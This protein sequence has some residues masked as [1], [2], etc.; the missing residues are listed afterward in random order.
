M[1]VKQVLSEA[2]GGIQGANQARGLHNFIQEI[3]LCSNPTQEQVISYKEVLARKPLMVVLATIIG[4]SR[5]PVPLRNRTRLVTGGLFANASRN[6][7]SV[8][9]RLGTQQAARVC[10]HA[11]T[12]R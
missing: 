3:R 5:R 10:R 2:L 6:F 8:P 7:V 4:R 11:G 9:T 12:G 1:S